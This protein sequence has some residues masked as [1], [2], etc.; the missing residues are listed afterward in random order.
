MLT[1]TLLMK[2]PVYADNKTNMKIRKLV[3]K[4]LNKDISLKK[5]DFH[6]EQGKGR[7]SIK[8]IV[9]YKKCQVISI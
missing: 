1:Y 4:M 5:L 8:A 7:D 9:T 6:P 2:E 3:Q